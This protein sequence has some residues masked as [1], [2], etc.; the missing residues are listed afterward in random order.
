MAEA[1]GE[2]S[3]KGPAA[4][5]RVLY[6]VRLAGYLAVLMQFTIA[7]LGGH[8]FAPGNGSRA[9]PLET[10]ALKPAASAA[11]LAV[12]P[13]PVPYDRRTTPPAAPTP[14]RRCLPRRPPP[15]S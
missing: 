11:Q 15:P 13:G 5:M 10:P 7:C 12:L 14:N 9:P 4:R 2:L 8:S 3:V 6:E 1:L